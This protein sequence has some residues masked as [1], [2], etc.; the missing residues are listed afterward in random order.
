MTVD[1]IRYACNA[2][3]FSDIVHAHNVCAAED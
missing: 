1:C 3:H 2:R